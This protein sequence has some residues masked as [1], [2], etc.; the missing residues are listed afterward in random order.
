MC[1]RDGWYLPPCT[2]ANSTF[3]LMAERERE[4]EEVLNPQKTSLSSSD[5]RVIGGGVASGIPTRPWK[6]RGPQKPMLAPTLSLSKTKRW[7]QQ[8]TGVIPEPKGP[9]QS[10]GKPLLVAGTGD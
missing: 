1:I 8:Q 7:R 6:R 3:Q 2:K 5:F 10:I 4:E 9:L